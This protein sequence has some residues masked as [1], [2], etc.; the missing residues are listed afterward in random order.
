MRSAFRVLAL[1]VLVTTAGCTGAFDG[2][3][4]TDTA[5]PQTDETDSPTTETRTP[6]EDR[7]VP[8]GMSADGLA[9]ADA[10]VSAHADALAG[11]SVTFRERR[12]RRYGNE[13]ADRRWNRT[14]RTAANRSRFRVVT[15]TENVPI[16][17]ASEGR[18]AVFAD[19]RRAYRRVETPNTSWSSAVRTA[20]GDPESPRNVAPD[21]A[22][23]DDLRVLLSAL[24]LD[25]AANARKLGESGTYRLSSSELANPDLLA[26]HLGVSSVRNVSFVGIVTPNGTLAEYRLTFAG[27][28]DGT[29]VRG[30]SLVEYARL[31]ETTVETP[32]WYDEA[33]RRTDGENPDGTAR[34]ATTTESDETTAA[35]A[36]AAI[37]ATRK[38]VRLD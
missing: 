15:E 10:L 29:Q 19:G 30:T 14:V 7:S 16:F 33:R 23:T 9:D 38:K 17:G 11:E 4:A 35:A 24:A 26:S 12:V 31:G 22:R 32:A 20:S 3:P 25:S 1:A 8:P 21:V 34:T 6:V 28:E 18:V 36:T 2:G 13:T 37:A 5:S 27:E